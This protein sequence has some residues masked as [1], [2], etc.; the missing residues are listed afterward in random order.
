MVLFLFVIMLIGEDKP[1]PSEQRGFQVP[2]GI[3][4]ALA[5]VGEIVYLLA[6]PPQPPLP[7]QGIKIAV[8][9]ASQ[10]EVAFGS[11]NAIGHTL[12]TQYLFAFEATSI[13]LL[14][15]MVGVVVLAKRRL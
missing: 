11:A 15:A 9:G 1:L 14:I 5:L 4:F 10:P 13:V 8:S 3:F 2:L 6:Q 7:Q 12:F